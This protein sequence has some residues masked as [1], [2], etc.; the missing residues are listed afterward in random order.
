MLSD[1]LIETALRFAARAHQG[2]VRKGTDLPYIVHP[3]GV[4]LVLQAAGERD[5]AVL[6]AALL[7]DTLEDAGVTTAALAEQFGP[8]VAEIVAGA[9]E[10]FARDDPWETRKQHTVE[11]LRTAPRAVQLVAAADKLHNLSSMVADHAVHGEAL[12][13]RFNRGRADIAWYYRAITASLQAG[14]LADHPLVRDLAATVSA[15]FGPE[16]A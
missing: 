9:S 1:P 12:W 10:P 7:H 2:Q 4:L 11:F 16:A 15:F 13:A 6:A 14:G 8:R 5:P 3:V